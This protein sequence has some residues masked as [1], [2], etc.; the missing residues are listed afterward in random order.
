MKSLAIY[1]WPILIICLIYAAITIILFL[2]FKVV[3]RNAN[4]ITFKD[5]L[6]TNYQFREHHSGWIKY[7]W[8]IMF[9]I[10]KASFD[11]QGHLQEW[12]IK[13][14]SFFPFIYK[15]SLA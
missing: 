10:I 14:F 3:L 15:R 11:K 13:L 12:E 6:G 9:M 1:L 8:Q 4:L 5:V 7:K 2:R